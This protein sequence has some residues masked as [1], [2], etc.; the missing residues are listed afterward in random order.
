MEKLWRTFRRPLILEPRSSATPGHVSLSRDRPMSLRTGIILSLFFVTGPAAAAPPSAMQEALHKAVAKS[1][2]RGTAALK[3]F[4]Q[5]DGSFGT[6]G[7]GGTA[8]VGLA[9]ME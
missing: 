3:Q 7:C 6:Y 8:L 2:D 4:Q 9:L 1:V 5:P